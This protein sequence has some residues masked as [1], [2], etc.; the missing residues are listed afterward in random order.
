MK[1]YNEYSIYSMTGQ[2]L[3]SDLSSS[4]RRIIHQ[5]KI[6]EDNENG[7]FIDSID[8]DEFKRIWFDYRDIIK[9]A[10]YINPLTTH[11]DLALDDGFIKAYPIDETIEYVSSYFD[12]IPQQFKLQNAES[13]DGI[14]R[15]NICIPVIENNLQL[16]IKA[17]R[18][19]GY[20]LEYP[21]EKD[22]AEDQFKW[23]KFKP[24]IRKDESEKIRQ[25]ETELFYLTP[26][27]NL[28]KIKHLGFSPRIR[29][30]LFVYPGR[31]LFLRG[32]LHDEIIERV[33]KM[34]RWKKTDNGNNEKYALIT[35]GLN[36]IPKDV[37]MYIDPDCPYGIFMTEHLSAEVITGIKEIA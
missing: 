9:C 21:E 14:P 18:I 16:I 35:I 17:M 29:N 15:I 8:F 22:I 33:G 12:L 36:K 13:G 4:I 3:S 34:L 10:S 1:R 24:Q 30:E 2:D 7:D 26:Y 31:V 5:L 25:E 19:C 20:I 37:E 23:L 6:V 11:M 32:T 28:G 27:R